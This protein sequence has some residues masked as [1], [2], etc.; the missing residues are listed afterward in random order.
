[1]KKCFLRLVSFL[2][3]AC[4]LG[5]VAVCA[6]DYDKTAAYIMETVV[7]PK[8]A[9]IGG[10]WSVIG[11]ARGEYAGSGKTAFNENYLAAANEA[12][13]K[14]G[15][16]MSTSK[17]TEYSRM[18]L[19]LSALGKNAKNIAG[20]DLY[21][22]LSDMGFVSKQG[23]NGS[24]FAL[25][26]LDAK[27]TSPQGNVTRQVLIR[28]ILAAQKADGGFSLSTS[29][30]S[31]IDITAMA[32]QSLAPYKCI[33]KVGDAVDS[34][35]SFLSKK[36][37]ADGSYISY[38]SK[39]CESACQVVIALCA[40]GISPNTD[41]RFVKNGKSVYASVL[42]FGLSDGSF[43]HV[44]DKGA[45][46]MATE[47]ALCAMAAYKRFTENKSAFYDMSGYIC[48]FTDISSSARRDSIKLLAK[49]G[50]VNGT[51]KTTFSHS[52]NVTR[53]E[54]C[55]MLAKMLVLPAAKDAGFSDVKKGDWY[56]GYVNSA[57]ASGVVNGKGSGKFC[58]NDKIT[59]EEAAVMLERASKKY[60]AEYRS[61]GTGVLTAFSDASQI[62]SWAKNSVAYCVSEKMYVS[63]SGRLSPSK[64][65]TREELAAMFCGF[66]LGV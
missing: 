54:F 40:L 18:I 19:A 21:S 34:A 44:A 22:G 41:S 47:Q 10:E 25:I 66:W 52:A 63:E 14:N 28:K 29:L 49:L 36:Q 32:L 16:Q 55:T 48:P 65:L 38:G 58:P 6:V 3:A 24:I 64:A 59:H 17:S 43:K 42:S 35:L 13:K 9:S 2:C 46:L 61:H 23:L 30:D 5:S 51:T 56:Y 62:S 12:V 53:A 1:M 8:N 33:P 60:A 50:V 37:N 57:F 7:S 11:I 4:L 20:Y 15:G 45:N 31:D 39:N 27:N 26:S